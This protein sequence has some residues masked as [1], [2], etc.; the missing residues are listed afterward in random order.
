M[1]PPPQPAQEVLCCPRAYTCGEKDVPMVVLSLTLLSYGTMMPC[2]S[3]RPRPPPM[4]P[5][6][7][8]TAPQP[9]KVVSTEPTLVP[10]LKLTSV[11]PCSASSPCMS[12]SG[13]GI[14]GLCCS[15]SALPASEWLYPPLNG[16]YPFLQGFVV[17]HLSQWIYPLFRWPPKV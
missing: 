12:V 7:Q 6:L 13:F 9:L 1:H 2:F 3:C 11:A 10:T 16:R 17:L 8:C 4:L 15:L 14:N 5:W